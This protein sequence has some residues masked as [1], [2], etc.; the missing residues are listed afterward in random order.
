MKH[1][2]HERQPSIVASETFCDDIDAASMPMIDDSLL[3]LTNACSSPQSTTLS[4]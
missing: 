3:E 4:W 1:L 2:R